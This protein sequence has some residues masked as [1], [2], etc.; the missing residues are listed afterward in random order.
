MAADPA[1]LSYFS[2]PGEIRNKIMGYVL[3]P[4][5]VY[6]YRSV[7]KTSTGSPETALNAKARSGVHLLAYC[8]RAFRRIRNKI[9]GYVLIRE[10]IDPCRSTSE[11]STYKAET[12]PKTEP[13]PGI[14][15]IA[16][17]KQAYSEGCEL[18]Y[19]SNTFHLP[20][21]ATFSWSDKL[22]AKHKAMIKR[23]SITIGLVELTPA[24]L[25]EIEKNMPAN[26]DK[27][28][29]KPWAE[30]IGDVLLKS[31]H[32]K[33]RHIADWGSLEELELR[34]Y[35]RTYSFP[36]R[37]VVA[38]WKR[39]DDRGFE[40]ETERSRDILTRSYFFDYANIDRGF[41]SE[42]ERWRDILTRS[43]F[44]DYGNILAK[45]TFEGWELTKKWLGERES[46]EMAEPF[47]IGAGEPGGVLG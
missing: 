42:I 36:Y 12:T 17:C 30:A 38:I 15:L 32:S 33:L 13:R 28:E 14:Q 31:W 25:T 23:V 47:I 21:T 35:G 24:I 26:L 1:R 19:S 16:T 3:V 6:P 9:K 5:D 44:Y 46:G 37:E 40:N 7:L 43:Y 29:A 4:G 11:T 41:E 45:V 2:L 8:K 20:P 22:T 10:D 27:K 18:F 39:R 34:S